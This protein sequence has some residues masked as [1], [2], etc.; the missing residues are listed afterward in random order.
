M[1]G[2]VAG[3]GFLKTSEKLVVFKLA[4]KGISEED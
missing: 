2:N 3:I 1:M 4:T